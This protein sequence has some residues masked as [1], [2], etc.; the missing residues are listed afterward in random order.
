MAAVCEEGLVLGFLYCEN[1]CV[2]IYVLNK[3]EIFSAYKKMCS[4][5]LTR[6]AAKFRGK[7]R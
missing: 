2:V 3:I 5:I 4:V 1:M 6:E 7:S